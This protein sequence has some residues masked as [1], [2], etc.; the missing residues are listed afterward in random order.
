LTTAQLIPP[1]P[2]RSLLADMSKAG[3]KFGRRDV[4]GLGK[5]A[6]HVEAGIVAS[7]LD[8]ADEDV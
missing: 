7:S 8:P 2:L 6:N 4:K 3:K 5:S 1:V